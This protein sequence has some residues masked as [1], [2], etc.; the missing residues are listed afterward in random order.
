MKKCPKC[1]TVT[2]E[3]DIV[4]PSCKTPVSAFQSKLK[5]TKIKKSIF[6][7]LEHLLL[8]III[9]I[10]GQH[11]LLRYINPRNEPLIVSNAM[12]NA[13][14]LRPFSNNA[15]NVDIKADD[16]PWLDIFVVN[17]GT[18]FEKD[19][20]LSLLFTDDLSISNIER[21]YIPKALEAR[22]IKQG[23]KTNSFYEKLSSLPIDGQ[24]QYHLIL[25]RF[26]FKD[27]EFKLEVSSENRNWSKRI[28][29]KPKIKMAAFLFLSSALAQENKSQEG[30]EKARGGIFIGGYDPL[31]IANDI[32]IL[33]QNKGLITNIDAKDIKETVTTFK[34]GVLFGGINIMKFN[35][36][37]IN[38]LIQN[39][40]I[41]Y[42]EAQDM[43]EK[44]KNSGGVLIGGYNVLV[45]EVEVLNTL[46]RKGFITLKEGQQIIDNAKE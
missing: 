20:E 13:G 6:W 11:F 33:L 26:I 45:L 5:S 24:L 15:F 38:K 29:I 14:P 27:T 19:L 30:S 17:I 39:N 36:M 8:P 18:S 2:E 46:L 34:E 3:G 1:N 10:A 21:T 43:V 42:F 7:F 12:F 16:I 44:S 22:V 41:T 37:I 23:K 28:H 35:E 40:K 9:F 25:N 4:C 32:F 31:Y